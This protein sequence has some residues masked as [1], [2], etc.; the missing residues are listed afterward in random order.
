MRANKGVVLAL[1][2]ALLLVCGS[3]TTRAEQAGSTDQSDSSTGTN[4][5]T[6]TKAATDASKAV[7]DETQK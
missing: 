4:K 3:V 2:A 1:L 5:K 7:T 6:K